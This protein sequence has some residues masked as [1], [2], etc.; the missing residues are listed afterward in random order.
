MQ[1]RKRLS[2]C[3]VPQ[4]FIILDVVPLQ[5]GTNI[6]QT[7][8]PHTYIELSRVV[9]DIQLSWFFIWW[10][11]AYD[12]VII[13]RKEDEVNIAPDGPASGGTQVASQYLAGEC[14]ATVS[15]E[16]VAYTPNLLDTFEVLN[17]LSLT[18]PN[19]NVL[20]LRPC[21]WFPRAIYGILYDTYFLGK[22]NTRDSF[23][24]KVKFYIFV[25]CLTTGFC[26]FFRC[27]SDCRD[28]KGY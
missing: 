13:L 25:R 4:E 6:R 9:D 28:F 3:D 5:A 17:L 11:P 8:A 20:A 19:Y 15:W 21:D 10:G 7:N 1:L 18:Y 16:Y 14:L 24:K 2:D 23:W 26:R 12:K 22:E 27:L